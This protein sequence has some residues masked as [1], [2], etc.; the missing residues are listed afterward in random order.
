LIQTS[1][2]L[3]GMQALVLSEKFVDTGGVVDNCPRAW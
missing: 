3:F 1:L 2:T